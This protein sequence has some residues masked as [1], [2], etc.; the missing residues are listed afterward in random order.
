MKSEEKDLYAFMC[1]N[2]EKAKEICGLMEKLAK[3]VSEA[4][5]SAKNQ[6]EKKEKEPERLT[7]EKKENPMS[8]PIFTVIKK[9]IKENKDTET[10]TMKEEQPK[11]EKTTKEN[12]PSSPIKSNSEDKKDIKEKA[13]NTSSMPTGEKKKEKAKVIAIPKIITP[14]GCRRSEPEDIISFN[15]FENKTKFSLEE[16]CLSE[17]NKICFKSKQKAEQTEKAEE[18]LIGSKRRRGR[19]SLKE[20]DSLLKSPKKE[21]KTSQRGSKTDKRGKKT[22][23]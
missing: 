19:P 10:K 5:D 1:Q 14:L 4:K 7:S 11:G 13:S 8:K 9:E 21:T 20:L 17:G 6:T 3:A 2:P 15:P 23:Y 22:K 16:L 18:N 12:Q